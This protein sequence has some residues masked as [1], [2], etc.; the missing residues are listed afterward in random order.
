M[1]NKSIS[2]LAGKGTI[3]VKVFVQPGT[4]QFDQ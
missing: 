4:I 1:N 3:V 2:L